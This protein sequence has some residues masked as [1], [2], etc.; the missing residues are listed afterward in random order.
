M[1]PL[2]SCAG[3]IEPQLPEVMVN[4]HHN[5][6]LQLVLTSALSLPEDIQL[7]Q[8]RKD[9]NA[10]VLLLKKAHGCTLMWLQSNEAQPFQ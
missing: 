4:W 5:V 1:I 8:V 7:L 2:L 6:H 9:S 3:N 10:H